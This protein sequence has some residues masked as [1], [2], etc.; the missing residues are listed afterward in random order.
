MAYGSRGKGQ[1]K[2]VI[3]QPHLLQN[4]TYYH[5]SSGSGKNIRKRLESN[6]ENMFQYILDNKKNGNKQK[7]ICKSK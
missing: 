5:F 1:S 4:I 2:N 3:Y 6:S 7:M